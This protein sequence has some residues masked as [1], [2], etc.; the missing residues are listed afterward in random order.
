[1]LDAIL[2]AGSVQ[3]SIRIIAGHYA[4]EHVTFHMISSVNT[5]FD[6]PFVRTTYPANWVS[7]YLLNNY[8]SCDPI[9]RKALKGNAPFC[10]SEIEPSS[11]EM[12]LFRKAQ[13]FGLGRQGFSIPCADPLGRKSVLSLNSGR[14]HGDWSKFLTTHRDDLLG[15]SM[16]LHLQAVAEAFAEQD[17]VPKL[18]PREYECLRWT[19]EGKTYSEIAIILDL[20]EHTVRSYLRVVRLKLDSVSLAQAV[21]R[22]S[23]MGLI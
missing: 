17:D 9:L 16:D 8:V 21:G 22:A 6:N 18:S 19:A 20:S 5:G 13:E 12:R 7:H 23:R 4:I 2:A 1:V 11:A 14:D 10:W 3:E 15:L